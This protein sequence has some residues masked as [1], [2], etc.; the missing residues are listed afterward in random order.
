MLSPADDFL[1]HQ[2][3]EPI[4]YPAT[5]DRRYYDRYFF[6]GHNSDESMFFLL[7]MGCYP[8]LG[9]I[10]AFAS[11]STGT[12]QVTT[13]GSR[14]LGGDRMNTSMVGSLSVE[15]VEG[16]RKLRFV[17]TSKDHPVRLDL[18]FDGAVP[19]FEEPPLFKRT[20]GRVIEQGIRFI[21]TGC[22]TGFIEADGQRFDLTPE[23]SWGA[24]DHSW[25]VRSIGFEREPKGIMQ[26]HK[27]SEPRAP[28]WIWTPMQFADYTVHFSISEF[29]SGE[30]EI[31]HVRKI[32]SFH[33]G[34]TVEELG[35]SEHNLI[36]DP[37][38]RE[39]QAG[40]TISF[41]DSD[42]SKRTVTMIPL[43]RT[44]LR[45]GTGYG[46]PDDWRHGKY[47]GEHWENSIRFDLTDDSV[48]AK[49]GPTH[50]L[51]RMEMDNG[52]VGFGT[53]ETQVYGA[54]PRYGFAT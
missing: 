49:I 4:R 50:V 32:S 20:M 40:S 14:E 12:T 46:G 5:S 45:A 33:R 53:F 39:L 1:I 7:G 3:F 38:T 21:Q 27:E 52:E 25:G 19:A 31:D 42:G 35:G 8:N 9:V 26:A 30:R 43:R 17:S 23:T 10:D 29:A 54:F 22:Y 2:T 48:T 51:C 24:R 34:G 15:V 28:L 36:L 37:V 18:T 41:R 11:V 47:M 44:Y 16:L 13:R 6:T